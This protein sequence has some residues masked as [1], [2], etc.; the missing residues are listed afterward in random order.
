MKFHD[1]ASR[2]SHEIANLKADFNV[3]VFVVAIK[4]YRLL[5]FQGP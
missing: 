4:P 5:L 1:I 2:E 3:G